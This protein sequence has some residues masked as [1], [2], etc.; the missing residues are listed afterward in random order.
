[1]KK[2]DEKIT[3]ATDVAVIGISCRFPG[4]DDINLFWN[5]LIDSKE[6]IQ[7]FDKNK[8]S[9][10]K[11]N[12][13]LVNHKN[14]VNA[15]GFLEEIDKFDNNF[16]KISALEAAAMDPQQRIFLEEAYHA[17]ENAGCAPDKYQGKI[18][19][20][21]GSGPTHYYNELIRSGYFEKYPQSRQLLHYLGNEKDFLAL[22]VAYALNL[23][24]PAMNINLASATGLAV[25][26]KACQSL[27]NGE[28]D[29]MLAGASSVILPNQFGYIYEPENIFSID[30]HC[31]PFDKDSTGTVLSSGV[32]VVVLKRLKDAI[33]DN[34]S[35]YA[36]IKG[37]AINNDG[38]NKIGFTAPSISGQYLCFKDALK[39]S[40]IDAHHIKFIEA[41]GT[42]THLGDPIEI[43]ALTQGFGD[44]N[45][46]QFCAIGSVKSNIGHAQSAAGIAGFIKLI[47]SIKNK[48]IPPS[49]NF[50]STNNKINFSQTPFYVNSNLIEWD[51]SIRIGGVNALAM[52][53]V[54]TH[55]IAQNY[56]DEAILDEEKNEYNIM[57]LSA[58]TDIALEA[59][60]KNLFLYLKSLSNDQL[61]NK[62]LFHS[63]AYTLQVG[64]K[65]LPK[66]MA[67]ICKS[68]NDFIHNK[69][70]DSNC[71]RL[72]TIKNKWLSGHKISWDELYSNTPRKIHLPNYPFEKI[73][74]W[75]IE[76]DNLSNSDRNEE[77]H[78][79]KNKVL[80]VKLIIEE[81]T[82]LWKKSLQLNTINFNDNFNELGGDSLIAIE[83]ISEIEKKLG[84][85]LSISDL[86]KNNTILGLSN[87]IAH[88]NSK[89]FSKEKIITLNVT[90]KTAQSLFIIHPGNGELYFYKN[91]GELLSDKINL[92][93]IDNN[94]YNDITEKESVTI[95]SLAQRY[96][97]LIKIH[98]PDGP[99]FLCG[100]SFGGAIAFEMANQLMKNGD[101]VQHLFLIDSWAKYSDK[102]NNSD[103]FFNSYLSGHSNNTLSL[104]ETGL[105]GNLLWKRM[106]ALFNYQPSPIDTNVTLLKANLIND[107]Y[108]DIN[109]F[110]NHW[111][112]YCQR[113]ISTI[114]IDGTHE[115]ILQSPGLEILV[116]TII[117]SLKKTEFTTGENYE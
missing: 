66:K 55:I 93:G 39:M 97:N 33:N 34:D 76:N 21:A 72:L 14:Y 102:F 111:Q 8:L 63:V 47:L 57:I 71:I 29:V 58:N 90:N 50:K 53:G 75:L 106:E 44:I 85:K 101:S 77:E 62:N 18:G 11:A 107:E 65:D 41:H 16:F 38:N 79:I 64:R 104:S 12:E 3:H 96:V 95:Y 45:Q 9:L 27:V 84:I 114:L 6:L 36:V 89:D 113:S 94:I 26:V 88:I 109:I 20:Y 25:I 82:Q 43:A 32:G 2:D 22:R 70:S 60:K 35:I 115:T 112:Q 37:Y 87:Y 74:H 7:Q 54:N 23:T 116:S 13:Y 86:L 28:A 5:N 59:M 78:S 73:S 52:G 98:Q 17:L 103:Y 4:S 19:I 46:N 49:L 105:W 15:C 31:R 69:I 1:M 81:V 99:Y 68:L 61:V 24:G 117:K 110:D 42:G 10:L 83:L 80:D 56:T 48:M 91:M 67:F 92:I 100:W 108:K 30:G 51:D 40:N